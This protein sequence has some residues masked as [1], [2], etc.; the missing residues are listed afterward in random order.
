MAQHSNSRFFADECFVGFSGIACDASQFLRVRILVQCTVSE[1][2]DTVITILRC[3][4]YHDEERGYQFC[5]RCCFQNLQSG[6]QCVSCGVDC[7][8]NH[9]VSDIHFNQHNAHKQRIVQQKF[10]SFF[11][12]HA[13]AFSSFCQSSNNFIHFFVV[14]RIYEDSFGYIKA[15]SSFHDLFFV[16]DQND[17]SQFVS[18]AF[19]SC[20]QISFFIRFGQ[21]NYLF[22]CF[23]FCFHFR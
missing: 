14:F 11:Q 1:Q 10:S 12:S 20:F 19:S 15:A 22:V 13:F 18:Q 3:V 2:Q 9:T 16:T 17:V 7:A 23:C 8:G 6:T 21:Y 5:A 4:C